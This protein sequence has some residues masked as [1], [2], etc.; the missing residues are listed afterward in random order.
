MDNHRQKISKFTLS[1]QEQT[2]LPLWT[3]ANEG[4]IYSIARGEK[5]NWGPKTKILYR[6][7]SIAY[8]L[9]LTDLVL[10]ILGFYR[11]FSFWKKIKIYSFFNKKKLTQVERIFVGFGASSEEYL[12][13][14]YINKSPEEALRIDCVTLKGVDELACPGL[15][16]I[17]FTIMRIAIGYTS[18]VRRA[19]TPEISSNIIDFLVVGALN[20]GSYVFYRAL[21]RRAKLRGLNEITFLSLDI[22]SYACV[23]EKIRAIYLQHGLIALSILI[24]KVTRIDVLTSEEERYFKTFLKDTYIQK[25]TKEID[26]NVAKKNTLIVLSPNVFLEKRLN[27]LPPLLEWAASL[28][29][30]IVIRAT[31]KVSQ[32]ELA[33]IQ[34]RFP[35]ALLDDL[36]FSL[37][38][39][40]EKWNP[41][42]VASWTSTGLATALD[43]GCLP[44]SFCD[45]VD[46]GSTWDMI[47]PM[48][49]RTLFWP[50][51]KQLISNVIQSENVYRTLHKKLSS[52]QQDLSIRG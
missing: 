32:S 24:P 31:P 6:I 51:D 2:C 16:G 5:F 47:Y 13:S 43:Y 18:K 42:L 37:N 25:V 26:N 49:H 35:Y 38:D 27:I 21:W 22:S 48:N 28:G 4:V 30:Q 12:Y 1:L 44:I 11:A 7:M 29:L 50:R 41:K 10:I 9:R 3:L 39:S 15:F 52:Y 20:I 40:F 36:T 33:T 19:K 23:D 34:E 46:T 45:P 14:E 8:K 17:F